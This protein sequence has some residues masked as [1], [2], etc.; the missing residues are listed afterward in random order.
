MLAHE[1]QHMLHWTESP[2]SE[3]WLDEG[4]SEVVA[5]VVRGTPSRGASYA[6]NP[7]RSLIA[8]TNDPGSFAGQYDG[9]YLIAQYL[10]DRFGMDALGSI[11]RAG[12]PPGAIESFLASVGEPAAFDEVYGDWLVANLDDDQRSER[13]QRYRYGAAD[14]EVRLAG[15]LEPGSERADTVAQFGSDY[16]E[17]EPG[18]SALQVQAASRV[19]IAPAL[20]ADDDVVW[21]SNRADSLDATLTRRVDLRDR[22]AARLAFRTW[23]N[24]ERDFDHCYVAVSEDGGATWHALRGLSSAAVNPTGN[25]YGPSFTGRSG[26]ETEARWIDEQVD[27]SPY[28]GREILVRFEYVTDQGT[29]QHGWL[30]DD[31]AVEESGILADSE[32]DQSAWQADGFV[33]TALSVPSRLMIQVI[34]GS[35]ASMSVSRYW[36]ENGVETV[37]P[38]GNSE[39][40]RTVVSVSGVTPMTVEP[41]EYRIRALP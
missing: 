35:G 20:G 36:I 32:S 34:S 31:I 17:I 22:Q 10:A 28:A 29:T 3:T 41:M 38:V 25:A 24:T 6:Q 39:G 8:W 2:A 23:F 13:P 12:R 7:D 37:I 40:R 30:V 14:P 27:L 21:W 9:S 16:L 26:G 5:S 11:T 1:M 4:V 18:T 15:R 19:K 33:R